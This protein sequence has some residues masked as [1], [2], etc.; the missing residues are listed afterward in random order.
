MPVSPHPI[1]VTIYS[2][3]G[4]TPIEGASFK[5]RNNTKG[6]TSSTATSNASGVAAVD[7]ANLSGTTPYE[8]GDSITLIAYYSGTGS[9][10]S[11]YTV[12]GSSYT[13]TLTLETFNTRDAIATMKTI[14]DANWRDYNT[15]DMTPSV[16]YVANKKEISMADGDWI[17]L[18][19]VDE[20][21][22]PFGIGAQEW[23]HAAMISCDIRTT[24]KRAVLSDIRAH[25][26]KL[27][28]ELYRIIKANVPNPDADFNLMVPIR[29]RDL[30]D[31]T[32]GMG[33]MVVDVSLRYWE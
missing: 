16:D 29:R 5:V 11:L 14:I 17:L 20:T 24:Y 25:L 18:Y 32:L 7:L 4:I 6:T 8:A 1:Q 26:I 15:D 3:D 10:S 13:T 27:K 21:I 22:D 31:K 9:T 2:T 33:R 30:S 23:A 12:T 28:E 19:E